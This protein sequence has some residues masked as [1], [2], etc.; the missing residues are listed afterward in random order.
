MYVTRTPS[1]SNVSIKTKIPYVCILFLRGSSKHNTLYTFKRNRYK[2][3]TDCSGVFWL[4]VKYHHICGAKKILLFSRIKRIGRWKYFYVNKFFL[5][6]CMTAF[7]GISGLLTLPSIRIVVIFWKKQI[8]WI[9]FQKIKGFVV[10]AFCFQII[11]I[12][13]KILANNWE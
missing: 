7:V 2:G 3:R 10:F 11:C 6:D 13:V 8:S 9:L 1:L 4:K 5:S 12:I